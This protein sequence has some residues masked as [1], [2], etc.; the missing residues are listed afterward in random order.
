MDIGE[1]VS[2]AIKY[3]SSDWKKVIILGV[4]FLITILGSV[5]AY[6]T[7]GISLILLLAIIPFSGYLFRILKSTYAGFDELPEFDEFGNMF[8]DGLKVVVVG[9]VYSIIPMIII[10]LGAIVSLAALGVTMGNTGT[11][12]DPTALFGFLGDTVII[13]LIV[14]IIFYI[15]LLI[16]IANM[17]LYDGEIMAAFRFGEILD[18]ISM[19]GWV[20]YIV[21]L[22]VMFILSLVGGFVIGL[23]IIIPFLGIFIAALIAYPYLYML[24]SRALALLFV[25]S[26]EGQKTV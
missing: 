16:A 17:A 23:I 1:I 4:M 2:D 3:P 5:L 6:Y 18:R 26:E 12:T 9:I 7:M 15:F 22:V 19:I 13:G 21:W 10:I 14:W 20:D 25:S 11:I 8:M 24:F